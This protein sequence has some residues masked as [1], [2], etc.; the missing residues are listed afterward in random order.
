[1]EIV[2]ER[3]QLGGAHEFCFALQVMQTRVQGMA[4]SL[5]LGNRLAAVAAD[6]VGALVNPLERL[7]DGLQNLGVGLLE[8]QL[9]VDFVV[10][11][12]L[13]GQVALARV[14]VERD[15]QRIA[16][17]AGEDVSPFPQQHLFEGRYV[18]RQLDI[19]TIR[20]AAPQAACA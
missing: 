18:H 6:A 12:R 11:G 9:D 5:R 20:H 8:L 16:A 4:F 13:I 10:A 7:F 15:R 19:L 1:M 14:R 17:A 3:Q 2:E